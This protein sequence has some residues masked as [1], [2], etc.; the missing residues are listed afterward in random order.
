MADLAR[1]VQQPATINTDFNPVLYFLHLVYWNS[2]FK[3]RSGFLIAALGIALVVYVV[4]L[5][6]AP[7]AIFASGFAASGLEVVLLLGF[8]ILCG[9]LYRQLGVIVTVFMLGLAIG[10]LLANR[11]ASQTNR[12]NLGKLALAIA[13]FSAMLPFALLGLQ[14]VESILA[15]KV[16]VSLLTLALAIFVGMEFPLASRIENDSATAS[17]LYT[18]DFIGGF[19]G[20]LLPSALVIPVFGVGPACFLTAGLNAIAAWVVLRRRD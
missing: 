11:N 1:A 4:R 10:A 19:L 14:H 12:Q 20:A 3:S 7:L 5:R 18:A 15:I 13:A 6:P 9:S 17:R 2:Q 16:I 8:Q